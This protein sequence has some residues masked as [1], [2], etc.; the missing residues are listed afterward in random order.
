MS[1]I[2]NFNTTTSFIE[3]FVGNVPTGTIVKTL[4][5]DSIGDG[6][7]STTLYVKESGTGNTGWV[8]K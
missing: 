6:R 8:G 2:I 5:Y 1:N 4:G 3:N 7:A